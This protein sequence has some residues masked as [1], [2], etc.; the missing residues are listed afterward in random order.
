MGHVGYGSVHWWVTKCDLLSALTWRHQPPVSAGIKLGIPRTQLEPS[1]QA[2]SHRVYNFGLFGSD[3]PY[4]LFDPVFGSKFLHLSQCHL[5]RWWSKTVIFLVVYTFVL[6]VVN[7]LSSG[8]LCRSIRQLDVVWKFCISNITVDV[9]SA[10]CKSHYR[11]DTSQRGAENIHILRLRYTQNLAIVSFTTKNIHLTILFTCQTVHLTLYL[12]STQQQT[13]GNFSKKVMLVMRMPNR[14]SCMGWTKNA[15]LQYTILT[16]FAIFSPPCT[17]WGHT[18]E[19][20]GM[21]N[22]HW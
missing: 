3:C 18:P 13:T 21:T 15:H 20:F 1:L 6:R 2:L 4:P 9:Q 8:I 10:H 12:T 11:T 7:A 19:C 22:F 14:L 17:R 16:Q 5:L